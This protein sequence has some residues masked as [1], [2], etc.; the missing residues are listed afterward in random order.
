[1]RDPIQ[2][3]LFRPETR[4]EIVRARLKELS[5]IGH[6]YHSKVLEIQRLREELDGAMQIAKA[7]ADALEE[8]LRRIK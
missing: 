4:E 8:E 5:N 7:Y 2:D 6:L 1:M 3:V